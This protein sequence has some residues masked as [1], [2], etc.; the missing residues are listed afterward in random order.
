[1]SFA[2]GWVVAVSL[3]VTGAPKGPPDQDPPDDP[4]AVIP[5]A[6]PR[7]PNANEAQDRAEEA[8][9]AEVAKKLAKSP[10]TEAKL[11]VPIYPGARFDPEMSAS[12]H[13][14]QEGEGVVSD[15]FVFFSGDAPAKV[16]E[17]YARKTGKKG[18]GSLGSGGL[19]FAVR[20]GGFF[21]D[22]GVTVQPNA[23][24][25]GWRKSLATTISIRKKR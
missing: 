15:T 22:L 16:A 14:Q 11:G 19:L 4:E 9:Q 13:G 10:P 17:F 5:D 3:V 6:G 12:F 20:G 2:F 23:F 21:P 8:R 24:P 18:Q 7:D 25:E 1:M